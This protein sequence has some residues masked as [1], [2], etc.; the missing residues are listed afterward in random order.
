[1]AVSLSRSVVKRL[2]GQHR[3]REVKSKVI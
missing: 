2:S 3:G 1:M